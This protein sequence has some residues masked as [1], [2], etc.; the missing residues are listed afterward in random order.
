[1]LSWRETAGSGAGVGRL[2]ILLLLDDGRIVPG[3][4]SETALD[5]QVMQLNQRGYHYARRPEPHS[6]AGDGIEHPCRY[7][8]DHAARYLDVNDL[9]AGA[10]LDILASNATPIQCVPAIMDLDLLPDMGRMTRRLP[11]AER[12]GSSLAPIAAVSVPQR[13]TR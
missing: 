8:D 12:I 4:S 2:F 5:E 1:M 3:A 7:H 11:S 6:G 13:S 9:A 10:L